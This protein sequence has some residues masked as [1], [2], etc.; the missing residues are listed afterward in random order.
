VLFTINALFHACG[1]AYVLPT[2]NVE[3]NFE[4]DISN[5]LKQVRCV[6][7]FLFETND[8]KLIVELRVRL[9]ISLKINGDIY[10]SAK[11]PNIANSGFNTL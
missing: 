3:T 11:E 2:S 6:V 8:C 7:R 1:S 10:V 5:F 9:L 4:S